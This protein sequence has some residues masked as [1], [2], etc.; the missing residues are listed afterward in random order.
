MDR[1]C[2]IVTTQIVRIAIFIRYWYWS[3]GVV[4]Y[5]DHII[6]LSP[7]IYSIIIISSTILVWIIASQL[8][9][10]KVEFRASVFTSILR[11]MLI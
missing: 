2:N 6:R 4:L 9:S 1:I 7:T 11:S 8:L 10:K 5:I 3:F